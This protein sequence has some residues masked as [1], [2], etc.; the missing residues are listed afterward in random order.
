MTL[1]PFKHDFLNV[2][3]LC[4]LWHDGI[5]EHDIESLDAQKKLNI[6]LLMRPV[7]DLK[8]R[9]IADQTDDTLPLA[10]PE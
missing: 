5:I 4:D 6:L 9:P 3:L 1:T 8:L 7:F 2:E 10:A